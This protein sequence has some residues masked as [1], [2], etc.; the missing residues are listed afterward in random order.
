MI[1]RRSCFLKKNK[2]CTYRLSFWY[3]LQFWYINHVPLISLQRC[4]NSSA[5]T[6]MLHFQTVR[7]QCDLKLLLPSP[8][9]VTRQSCPE[10]TRCC[11]GQRCWALL[12][13]PMNPG[14]F[15]LCLCADPQAVWIH[16][17]CTTRG[18]LV[19]FYLHGTHSIP[20]ALHKL[21][22]QQANPSAW[23]LNNRTI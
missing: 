9:S 8:W 4:Y 17:R 12:A 18:E 21:K 2:F 19:V 13:V 23:Q 14:K 15:I 1:I 5:C 3:H 7:D 16:K 10:G 6:W 20:T 11:Q 22:A